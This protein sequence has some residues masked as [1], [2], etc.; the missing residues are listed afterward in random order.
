MLDEF[1]AQ[2]VSQHFLKSLDYQGLQYFGSGMIFLQWRLK[3]PH[4]QQ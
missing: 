1:T 4:W 3:V 2:M